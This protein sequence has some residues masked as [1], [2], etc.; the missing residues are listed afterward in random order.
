V[1]F[2]NNGRGPP[3][4]RCLAPGFCDTAAPLAGSWPPALGGF[5]PL[6]LSGACARAPIAPNNPRQ[7]M[8]II[9][10]TSLRFTLHLTPES[11]CPLDVRPCSLASCGCRHLSGDAS[12]RLPSKPS[13]GSRPTLDL[14]SRFVE[15]CLQQPKI[16][17]VPFEIRDRST[18]HWNFQ[19]PSTGLNQRS[20]IQIRISIRRFRIRHQLRCPATRPPSRLNVRLR[21]ANHP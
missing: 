8:P 2:P 1:I 10:N 15:I 5:C 19:Y 4:P 7:P 16:F 6:E 14:L 21:I 20:R 18:L 13:E 12:N 3:S 17:L 11:S 9:N